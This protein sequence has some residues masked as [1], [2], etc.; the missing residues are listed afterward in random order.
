MQYGLPVT[1]TQLYIRQDSSF[2]VVNGLYNLNILKQGFPNCGSSHTST[3]TVKLFPC[4]YLDQILDMENK[5]KHSSFY[6][7]TTNAYQLRAYR[8]PLV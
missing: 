2:G 5:L 7:I 8:Y 3:G 4:C 1:H 6:S